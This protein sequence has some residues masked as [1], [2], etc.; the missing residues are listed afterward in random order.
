MEKTE[1]DVVDIIK[2]RYKKIE[3]T[4]SSLSKILEEGESSLEGEISKF[5][6]MGIVLFLF[7][8]LLDLSNALLI[9]RDITPTSYRDLFSYL[10]KEKIISEKY[11]ELLDKI[12]E[13]RN[14]LLF[15]YEK[16]D[17]KELFIWMK[18]NFPRIR[19]AFHSIIKLFSEI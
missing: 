14:I 11:S 13:L 16:I 3:E 15:G 1:T 2:M 6:F 7:Q 9:S 19:E 17:V 10:V 4:L 8:S 5:G 12:V 18:E